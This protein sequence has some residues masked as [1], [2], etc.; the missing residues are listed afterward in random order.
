M[1]LPHYKLHAEALPDA[2]ITYPVL[3]APAEAPI[4]LALLK[5]ILRSKIFLIGLQILSIAAGAT[6]LWMWLDPTIKTPKPAHVLIPAVTL[7]GCFLLFIIT[8]LIKSKED[9]SLPII[10][11]V[12]PSTPVLP[13]APVT[14]T[15]Q[16]SPCKLKTEVSFEQ[17]SSK[18]FQE[19]MDEAV[20]A[21]IF[22]DEL[23]A[24]DHM[25]FSIR[26]TE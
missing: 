17:W 23:I 12:S 10:A 25:V 4:R 21:E 22:N 18:P 1:A 26:V 15:T 6:L 5:Q 3:L 16:A 19:I 13:V 11:D 20:I 7:G 24:P 2:P 9:D 14:V 8:A